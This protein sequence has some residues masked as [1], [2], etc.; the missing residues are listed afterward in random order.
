MND[1]TS[2]FLKPIHLFLLVLI[3]FV[4]ILHPAQA[5]TEEGTGKVLFILDASGSMWGRVEGK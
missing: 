4:S 3:G 2:V 5:A 1:P